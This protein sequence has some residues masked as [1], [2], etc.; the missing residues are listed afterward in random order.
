MKKKMKKRN[1][2]WKDLS[3]RLKTLIK[4]VPNVPEPKNEFSDFVEVYYSPRAGWRWRAFAG[5][6][7]IGNGSEGYTK[8]GWAS[9][10]AIVHG[11][12]FLP[13][14]RRERNGSWS[15]LR[16]PLVAGFGAKKR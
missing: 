1:P 7:N 4:G 13:V 5:N 3:G 12:A 8:R 14:Y 6:R 2:T 10:Q 15:F 16:P 11:P 9:H